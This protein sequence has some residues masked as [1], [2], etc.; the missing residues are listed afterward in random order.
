[1]K[2]IFNTFY[3]LFIAGIVA[4]GLL[5]LATLVPVPG[6]FKVKVVKS[7]SM[8]PAIPTGSIVVIKPENSYSVGD[9]IT[10]GADTKTQVP[11]THRIIAVQGSGSGKVFTTQ[12]DANDAPDTAATRL[13]DIRGKVVFS[14]PYVGYVLDFGRKP[15]GFALLV[16]VPALSIIFDEIMKIVREIRRIRRKKNHPED[17]I[18]ESASGVST[19]VHNTVQPPTVT[20]TYYPK[21]DIANK[22]MMSASMDGIVRPQQIRRNIESN[23]ASRAYQV[24]PGRVAYFSARTLL[25]AF[26]AAGCMF[27]LSSIGGTLSYFNDSET[28]TANLL[29][30][31]ILDV[32][33]S[34]ILTDNSVAR[35]SVP[36]ETASTTE[37]VKDKPTSSQLF[38]ISLTDSDKENVPFLYTVFGEFNKDNPAGCEAVEL[39]VFMNEYHYDGLLSSFALPATSAAGTGQFI[40]SAPTGDSILASGAICAGNLI[41]RA[42]PENTEDPLNSPFSDEER[43]PFTVQNY[44][45]PVSIPAAQEIVAESVVIE[46][47][48]ETAEE[49]ITNPETESETPVTEVI[50]EPV[51]EP[52]V[53]IPLVPETS[54][55][56]TPHT[57]TETI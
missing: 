52:V 37:E 34:P 44:I 45:E 17:N 31:G 4:I 6:N 16:G 19:T 28:S 46:V 26:V 20:S 51:S 53:D 50:V 30:A 54:A 22:R 3:Y 1:M 21:H 38:R 13:S 25:V 18:D 27:G 11:T 47:P 8:S 42:Y 43:Y 55:T 36:D 33:I 24:Q 35:L 48:K 32:E 12:G 56:E 29:R 5:L 49:I 2:V 14:A 10:F 41:F 39:S 9:I 7:G 23:A 15:L 57:S 40:V